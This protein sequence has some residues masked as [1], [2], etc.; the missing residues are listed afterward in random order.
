M[1]AVLSGAS[2]A[3]RYQPIDPH[4]YTGTSVGA[5]NAAIM[6][7]QPGVPPLQTLDALIQI[8]RQQIANIPGGCGNGVFRLRGL[9]IQELEPAC[10]LEPV[11]AFTQFSLD[12]VYLANQ[13]MIRMAR[14]ATSD[15]PLPGRLLDA[16]DISAFFDP[17]PLR[18][19]VWGTVDIEGLRRSSKELAV[20]TSSWQDGMTKIFW[21]QEI[22]EHRELD[23]ILASAA[24][25]G[26]FPVVEIHGVPYVDGALT[27]N[28]PL[29]PAIRAGA[30]VLHVIYLDPLVENSEPPRYP[31]TFEYIARVFSIL[32]AEQIRTDIRKAQRINEGLALL[33]GQRVAGDTGDLLRRLPV[34]LE[35]QRRMQREPKRR[36]IIHRYLPGGTLAGGADLLNFNIDHIEALIEQGYRDAVEH[37]CSVSDCLTDDDDSPDEARRRRPHPDEDERERIGIL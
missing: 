14:F 23:A 13:A 27:M 30:N 11:S 37:D 9:P 15:L 7:S 8:W 1:R 18:E 36:L 33:R 26:V 10:F 35:L 34:V 2:P 19:L 12:W 4:V 29:K 20:A 28:T 24:V 32:A 5:Y 22:V 21:K 6:A 3:T 17:Q 31:S 16:P 25:P